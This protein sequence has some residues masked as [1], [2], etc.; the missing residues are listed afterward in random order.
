MLY[1]IPNRKPPI[2]EADLESQAQKSNDH[3]HTEAARTTAPIAPMSLY[4]KMVSVGLFLTGLGYYC[5]NLLMASEGIC[6]E[7]TF[8]Y[9]EGYMRCTYVIR[10][11]NENDNPNICDRTRECYNIFPPVNNRFRA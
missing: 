7:D 8:H 1:K 9:V 6:T 5:S 3:S 11:Q 4:G 2:R 10:C